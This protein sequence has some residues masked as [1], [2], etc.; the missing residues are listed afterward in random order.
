MTL[1]KRLSLA[2][3]NPFEAVTQGRPQRQGQAQPQ[4]LAPRRKGALAG[5]TAMPAKTITGKATAS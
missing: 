4:K 3:A 1:P 2:Q 5:V